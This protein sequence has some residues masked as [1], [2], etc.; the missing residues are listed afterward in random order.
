MLAVYT[1]EGNEQLITRVV[2]L[3]A[4]PAA[5]IPTV[6][7]NRGNVIAELDGLGTSDERNQII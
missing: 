2:T 4:S 1:Y 7:N 3:P 5:T 6:H